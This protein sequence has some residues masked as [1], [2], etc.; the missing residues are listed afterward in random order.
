V[1]FAIPADWG[2]TQTRLNLSGNEGLSYFEITPGVPLDLPAKT[3]V[4]T[5]PESLRGSSCKVKVSD[6][7]ENIE[8]VSDDAFYVAP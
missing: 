4:Y 7:G 1:K 2:Y 8:D 5:I 6:Y 3:L